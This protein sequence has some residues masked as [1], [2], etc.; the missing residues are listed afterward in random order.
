[1]SA[2][3][4]VLLTPA[5]PACPEQTFRRVHLPLQE[6]RELA[7]AASAWQPAA[8]LYSRHATL[9]CS[10][11]RRIMLTCKLFRINTCESVSKQM[12]LSPFRINTY[13]KQGEGEYRYV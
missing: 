11:F 12:T 9:Q 10:S 2:G 3:S 8:T 4:L 1:M 6:V 7:P 13:K 5:A